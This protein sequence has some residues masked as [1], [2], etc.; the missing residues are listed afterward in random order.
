[1]DFQHRAGGD[2]VASGSESNRDRRERLRQLALETINLAKNPYSMRNCIGTYECKFCLTSHNNEG[3]YLAHT[4]GK[5]HQSNLARRAARE[6]QQSSDIVQSIK[7][8]YEVRKFIK[9]GRPSY[10]VTKQRDPGEYVSESRIMA[11][12]SIVNSWTEWGT[13]EL[14]C[15]GTAEGMCYPD[16]TP[17]YPW[18]TGSSNMRPYIRAISGRRPRRCIDQAQAQL[19]NLT[20]LLRAESIVVANSTDEIFD[21]NIAQVMTR[22]QSSIGPNTLENTNGKIIQKS[23]IDVC[24]PLKAPGEEPLCFNHQLSTPHFKSQYQFGLACPRD[25]L[26]TLGDTVLEAPTSVHTRYFE[27]EYYKPLLYSLWKRDSNMKWLQPPKP[28]CS[29]IKMFNDVDFWEKLNTKDYNKVT[30]ANSGYKTNLNEN[31]IA[32]DAADMMRMGKDVFYKK[33]ASANNQG[34]YWLR[35]TFPHLR[36]HMLHFPTDGSYHLDASLVPLRPP[37]SGSHGL[38]LINQ[39]YPPLASEMKLFTD[40]DWRP[41]WAPLYSTKEVPPLALCTSNLH[42]NLLS[43]SDR[44]VVIEECETA[45]YRLLHDELGF[46]VITCPLRVLNE[47]GGGLHCV[48]WDIRRQDSCTDYF[49]NQNYESECQ[50]DLDNYYDKTLFSN[51]NEQKP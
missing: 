51:V 48:T 37:T 32:F 33:S 29:P 13:L 20:E 15:V 6:N 21:S 36:F 43:L 49:P 28:T 14:I 30:F 31:E 19:D 16:E 7:R 42:M 35:R 44:C 45:L 11:S 2:G 26:I 41:I 1:M 34:L 4:Q 24:R 25:V 12:S 39:D 18:H 5:K 10:N 3:S 46:D 23:K 50:L 17:S 9:I 22:K 27:S 8:H 38:V 40:N 47:F